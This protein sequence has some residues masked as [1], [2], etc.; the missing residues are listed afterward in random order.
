MRHEQGELSAEVTGT[1]KFCSA[2]SSRVWQALPTSCKF[3]IK[4][5]QACWLHQVASSPKVGKNM[6]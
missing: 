4:L 1:S 6:T 2:D 3:S 5:H